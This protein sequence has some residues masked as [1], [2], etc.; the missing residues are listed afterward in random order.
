MD[1][2]E[3]TKITGSAKSFAQIFS[4]E[5]SFFIPFYQ[6]PYSWNKDNITELLTDFLAHIKEINNERQLRQSEPYFLGSIV[7]IK[8]EGIPEAQIIDGQQRLTTMNMLFSMLRYFSIDND[9]FEALKKLVHV[10]GNKYNVM[11][12]ERPRLTVREKD[13]DFFKQR[14]QNYHEDNV[15]Q[16]LNA[17]IDQKS[18]GKTPDSQKMMRD[19][20]IVIYN[21]LAELSEERIGILTTFLINYCYLVVIEVPEQDTA[22]RVFSVLNDR[23]LDLTVSDLLKAEVIGKIAEHKQMDFAHNW[24]ALEDQLGRAAFERLFGHIRMIHY[25]TKA[26]G[27][28]LRDIRSLLEKEMSAISFFDDVKIYAD[29]YHTILKNGYDS[30]NSEKDSQLNE[31]FDQLINIDNSNWLP[32]AI[33][34][35]T[36]YKNHPEQLI[37][38]FTLLE[39]LAANMTIRRVNINDRISRYGELLQEIEFDEDVF[40]ESSTI[41]LT[42]EEQYKAIEHLNGNIYEHKAGKYI[43]LKLDR[44]ITEGGARYE[45]EIISIEHVLPQTLNNKWSK[46]YDEDTHQNWLHR[47]ANL[48]LLS[49]RKN[50]SLGN[51]GFK[52]KK[53]GYLNNRG[54]SFNLT[55]TAID[56]VT[57]NTEVLEKRQKN[58]LNELIKAWD[59]HGG[60]SYIPSPQ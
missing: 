21:K 37:K 48:V 11:L 39:R 30:E 18:G 52:E 6:R 41:M 44:Q 5:Y 23:G 2:Q 35:L 32:P 1:I 54:S 59:L 24:E 12:S 57:W 56:E 20:A 15:I 14:V 51:K 26:T 28:I 40:N 19:N 60:V 49:Q 10:Q 31:L 47:I 45:Y 55:K 4:D 33:Y 43:L 9:M 42:P 34:Y 46:W 3:R 16:I 50:S 36:K 13:S 8:E 22:Y 38:F 58:L 17:P 27:T 29:A 25:K 7:L 53:D